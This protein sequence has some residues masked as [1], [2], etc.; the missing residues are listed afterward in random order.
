[1]RP[2]RPPPAPG[3]PRLETPPPGAPPV[4]SGPSRRALVL[5]LGATAALLLLGTG[6]VVALAVAPG[7]GKKDVTADAKPPATSRADDAR[8]PAKET[9]RGAEEPADERPP[10]KWQP[11]EAPQLPTSL[12]K[13]EQ[14]E[15]DKAIESGV[16]YLKKSAPGGPMGDHPLSGLHPLVGLTLLECGVPTDVPALA[17]LIKYVR[18][19]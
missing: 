6:L 11:V 16:A 18:E 4:P 12:S 8:P 10:A 1:L 7:R 2:S 19:A 9:Y 14:A 13:E 15:V 5:V 3:A 17:N